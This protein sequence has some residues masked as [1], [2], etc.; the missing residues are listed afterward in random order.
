MQEEFWTE[1]RAILVK[2]EQ[3]K[4]EIC[5]G[6][7]SSNKF[8]LHW[9]TSLFHSY[10]SLS[11]HLNYTKYLVIHLA[12]ISL[13]KTPQYV[14]VYKFPFMDYS[15]QITSIVATTVSSF[16]KQWI[17][18]IGTTF[19][20]WFWQKFYTLQHG[21]LTNTRQ[22][23]RWSSFHDERYYS[24]PCQDHRC[25]TFDS[26][27][28]SIQSSPT[29][30]ICPIHEEQGRGLDAF[31]SMPGGLSVCVYVACVGHHSDSSWHCCRWSR[32]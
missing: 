11:E 28:H 24:G 3:S 21:L 18:L 8:S 4:L 19:F 7:Y 6:R 12:F 22:L 23:R 31:S 14:K 15:L 13:L 27:R 5:L 26:L 2:G 20:F 25:T 16:A 32:R 1:E 29:E 9:F 30:P 10:A 17:T